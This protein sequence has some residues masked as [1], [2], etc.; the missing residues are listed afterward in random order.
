MSRGRSSF[1]RSLLGGLSSSRSCLICLSP[2]LGRVTP[3]VQTSLVQVSPLRLRFL[4]ST[5]HVCPLRT[6]ALLPKNPA[7]QAEEEKQLPRCYSKWRHLPAR[8]IGDVLAA[9]ELPQLDTITL[10]SMPKKSDRLHLLLYA[11]KLSEDTRLPANTRTIDALCTAAAER[12]MAVG[13]L[14]SECRAWLLPGCFQS[15]C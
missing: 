2:G 5:C 12:Y 1:S 14:L 8:I 10:S 13:S 4:G 15:Q 3:L 11:L 6:G 9:L 7:D